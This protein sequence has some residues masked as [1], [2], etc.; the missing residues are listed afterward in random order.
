[1]KMK[2]SFLDKSNNR[3]GTTNTTIMDLNNLLSTNNRKMKQKA[4]LKYLVDTNFNILR[5]FR[6]N[7]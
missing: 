4:L 7:S 3:G 6:S 1:M 5:M 2:V